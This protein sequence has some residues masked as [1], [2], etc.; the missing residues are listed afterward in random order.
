MNKLRTLDDYLVAAAQ[1][2]Y[3]WLWDRTGV[4]VA[5]L[6]FAAIVGEQICWGP[7]KIWGFAFLAIFGATSAYAYMVQAKDLRLLN[8]MQR[9]WREN[10]LR[11]AFTVMV[12]YFTASD[13]V[14]LNAWGSAGSAFLLIWSYLS[15]VQV[16]DREP[17]DLLSTRKLARAGA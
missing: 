13:A 6:L 5:T 4:Y 8:S 14:K 15:C 11:L 2:I 3:L 16:R 10:G 9:R 17:K 12:L 1:E 7:I